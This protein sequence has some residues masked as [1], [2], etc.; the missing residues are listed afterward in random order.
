MNLSTRLTIAM[1][2]LVLLT[3]AAVGYLSYRNLEAAIVPAEMTRL[4]A[5]ARMQAAVLDSHVRWAR[6]D[7]LAATGSTALD[8]YLHAH[9]AGGTD[10]RDGSKEA[11]WLDRF[12]RVLV[13]QLKAKPE[14]NQFRLI[15]IADGRREILRVDRSGAGG[16]IRIV[17]DGELQQKGDRPYLK[18]TASL[19]RGEVYVSPIELNQEHGAVETPH[20]P[21]IRLGT[22]IFGPDG[23]VF[24]IIIVNID[25]RPAFA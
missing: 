15:G 8:S 21:V 14:Y 1:V 18:N 10:P 17:P 5:R 7:V 25:M 12:A 19:P 24:G 22:P 4:D 20:L 11:V 9:F 2:S 6:A 23:K 16:T 13:S 3:V